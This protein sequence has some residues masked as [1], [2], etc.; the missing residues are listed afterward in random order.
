MRCEIWQGLFRF[1]V[2]KFTVDMESKVGCRL[3]E[4]FTRE[5]RKEIVNAVSDDF[6][7]VGRRSEIFYKMDQSLRISFMEFHGKLIL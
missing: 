4:V 2:H 1:K 7:H 3:G 6:V 5:I